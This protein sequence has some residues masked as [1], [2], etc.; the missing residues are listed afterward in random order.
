MEDKTTILWN[1][2]KVKKKAKIVHY[3]YSEQDY[4]TDVILEKGIEFL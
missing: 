2:Q 4:S 3:G 1:G